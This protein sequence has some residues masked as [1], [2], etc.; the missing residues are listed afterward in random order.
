[1]TGI[2]TWC[3]GAQSPANCQKHTAGNCLI[4]CAVCKA[5]ALEYTPWIHAMSFKLRPF[6]CQVCLWLTAEFVLGYIEFDN[7]A[8]YCEYLKQREAIALLSQTH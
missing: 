5:R 1:M 4:T 8:D 6:I 3:C 2:S 7:L